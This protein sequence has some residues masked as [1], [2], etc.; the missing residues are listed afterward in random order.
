[1]GGSTHFLFLGASARMEKSQGHGQW[2]LCS[3]ITTDNQWYLTQ[4]LTDLHFNLQVL[5]PVRRASNANCK[6]IS[7]PFRTDGGQN[8]HPSSSSINTITKHR[9]VLHPPTKTHS[10]PQI[11]GSYRSFPSAQAMDVSKSV[12][13]VVV[14]VGA[15]PWFSVQRP[16]FGRRPIWRIN[17]WK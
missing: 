1:M 5:R 9:I 6:R 7:Y 16:T 14:V 13:Y 8:W 11:T 10:I 2:D 17:Q 4:T 3:S 15:C 12:V